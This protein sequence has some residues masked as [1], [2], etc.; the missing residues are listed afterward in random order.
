MAQGSVNSLTPEQNEMLSNMLGNRRRSKATA[1]VRL[2]KAYPDSDQWTELEGDSVTACCLVKDNLK[3]AHYI[4]L[5]DL[6]VS[7]S[8]VTCI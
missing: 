8:S 4:R 7:F 2:C 1:V 3:K 6:T 5:F